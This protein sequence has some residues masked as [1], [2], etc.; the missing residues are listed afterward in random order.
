VWGG[1]KVVVCSETGTVTHVQ[2]FSGQDLVAV[3]IEANQIQVL[4]IDTPAALPSPIVLPE[5]E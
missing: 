5:G 1:E 3:A 4:N 2:F